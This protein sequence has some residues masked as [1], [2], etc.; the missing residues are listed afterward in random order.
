MKNTVFTPS[1]LALL[2]ACALTLLALSVLL[3]AF[4]DA[5]VSRGSRSSP[6][7][8]STSAIGHAG[9]Y[10]VMRRLGRP[11]RR[12]VSNTLATV[13]SRGT[14]IVAEPDLRL[15][16]SEDGLR[17]LSAPRLLLVLP[18]WRGFQDEDRPAW[19]G[20]VMPVANLNPQ[21]T[22]ALVAGQSWVIRKE[23]PKEWEGN[24][25]PFKPSGSGGL[26]Q[27]IRSKE[28]RPV[29]GTEE[30]M[31]V[32]EMRE[33]RNRIWVLSDPDVMSNHGLGRG[34]NAAFMV[35]LLDALAATDGGGGA[36]APIVFDETV[37][38]FQAA[39]WSPMKLLF[40]FPFAVVTALVCAAALMMV[41]A[42][43]GRFGVARRSKRALDFGKAG[44]IANGARLLDYAGHHE[45]ILRGF[46]RLTVRSAAA[47]LHAPGGLAGK[48][49][50]EWLDRV[51]RSRGLKTSCSDIMRDAFD[52][53][54]KN[55]GGL[56]RLYKN[57]RK[58]YRWKGDILNGSG[59]SRVNRK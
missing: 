38:G 48:N 59:T 35:T 4:D 17:L 2:L 43:T 31:L 3:P 53:H 42:G 44:L 56:D 50:I 55:A 23:W 46:I 15:I 16:K 7:S 30:A 11:V 29:V 25:L 40:R 36:E 27:L 28:L 5:P 41:L 6:G 13:G 18:K 57:A 58:I 32:G 26:V 34:R 20:E 10:D 22:L 47:A 21:Q 33:G 1:T 54:G 24:E 45:V 49:L 51:G 12:A 37:H 52:K 8:F 14:L 39:Q 19:I 9:I